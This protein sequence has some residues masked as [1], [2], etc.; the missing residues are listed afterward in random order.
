MAEKHA[1]DWAALIERWKKGVQLFA[2]EAGR[3]QTYCK[4]RFP[5]FTDVD[6]KT[7]KPAGDVPSALPF[8]EFTVDLAEFD[9]GLPADEQLAVPQHKFQLPSVLAFP[10][11][12]SLLIEAEG[13]GRNQ[14][15]RV[16]QRTMLSMLTSLPA[17]KVRFTIIDPT[18]L[19]Q[20][21]SG[22]MHL[23]DYD[24]RLVSNRIW[25]E[26]N[27]INQRLADLTEHM[28]NVIQKYLRN[29]FTSIQEYNKHAGEVAEPFQVLVVAN[30]PAN[31]S[32]EATRRLVS[33]S[34]SGARCGVFT[35][36]SVDTKM[37]FPR[38]FDLADLEAHANTLAWDSETHNLP[39]STRS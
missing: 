15:V 39:G 16:F 14:A 38:N 8:G 17:G 19:G 13:A 4:Q 37:R 2:D 29:E 1:T 34:T 36:I 3:M 21:F 22:F 20:N 31:F 23:A 35:L 11:E 26:T 12:P 6:W 25:T 28:E 5:A 33:I 24:E 30:F 10:D 18:G 27:H 7:W 32:D 9:G